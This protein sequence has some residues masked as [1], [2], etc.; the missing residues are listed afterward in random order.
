M[1]DFSLKGAEKKVSGKVNKKILD[2]TVKEIKDNKQV[3]EKDYVTLISPKGKS[4]DRDKALRQVQ[5]ELA[6][7]KRENLFAVP[8]KFYDLTPV[9]QSMLMF[10]TSSDFVNP[11]TNKRTHMDVLQSY[12]TACVEEDDLFKVFDKVE[13]DVNGVVNYVTGKVISPRRYATMKQK[14]L[15]TWNA[16]PDLREVFSDMVAV[17][18]GADP[19]TMLK[20]AILTDALYAKEYQDK[21]QNR[22]MA[23]DILG[24][25]KQKDEDRNHVDIYVG[26]GGSKL[27]E[28]VVNITGDKYG[29]TDDDFVVDGEVVDDEER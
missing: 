27:V 11:V 25:G 19:E 9:E 21:N 17:E 6:T 16:N 22:K 29:V 2:E 23:L 10:Y 18:F 8:S 26:G 28:M 15:E 24:V 12:I 5:P 1:K 7:A 13:K 20:N 4:Q 3:T 14:A